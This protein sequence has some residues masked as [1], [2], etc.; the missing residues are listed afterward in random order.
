[1][2]AAEPVSLE[3]AR[4]L[5][6][7][8]GKSAEAEAAFT[9]LAK[10]DPKNATAQLHLGLLALRR[11]DTDAAMAFL[12]RAVALAPNDGECHKALGDVYGRSAQKKGIFGGLGLGKKCLAAYEKAVALS[13]ERVDFRQSLFEYYFRAPGIAG[14]S[15]DKATAEATAVKKLDPLT[16]RILFARMLAEDKKFA[17]AFA[18]FDE[19]LAAQPDDFEHLYQVGRLSAL[20]GEQLTRGAAALRRCLEVSRPAKPGVPSLANVHWRLGQIL[21]KQNDRSGARTAYQKSLEL[22]PGFAPATE[23]LKALKP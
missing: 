20:T 16:G 12:E 4:A 2:P 11:D 17:E 13:P 1:L 3:S 6:R 14:G 10:A 9:A 5:F 21:E 8:R 15:R 7:E 18:Q 19:V 23:S 22:D